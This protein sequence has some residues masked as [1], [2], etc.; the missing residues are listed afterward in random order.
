MVFKA[1]SDY[2]EEISL[3]WYAKFH[4]VH[5]A[6]DCAFV[7][8]HLHRIIVENF[9]FSFSFRFQI[10]TLIMMILWCEIQIFNYREFKLKI[11]QIEHEFDVHN[12]CIHLIIIDKPTCITIN[13]LF[14]KPSKWMK[15]RTRMAKFFPLFFFIIFTFCVSTISVVFQENS[16]AQIFFSMKIS[17]F[18]LEMNTLF[19]R[20]KIRL[21][22]DSIWRKNFDRR[23]TVFNIAWK[24][25]ERIE[26]MNNINRSFGELL[27]N[28]L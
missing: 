24:R 3:K 16:F 23:R 6:N 28:C 19:D 8:W 15:S 1:N 5:W 11:I 2:F 9:L 18:D 26:K 12:T 20:C 17:S 13:R 7:K 14:I 4:T 27:I 22:F 25:W 10:S 21:K